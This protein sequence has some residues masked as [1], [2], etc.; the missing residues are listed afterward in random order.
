MVEET[1]LQ[2]GPV[3]LVVYDREK[4][5]VLAVEKGEYSSEGPRRNPI[6]IIDGQGQPVSVGRDWRGWFRDASGQRICRIMRRRG[7]GLRGPLYTIQDPSKAEVGNFAWGRPPDGDH[8]LGLTN[9]LAITAEITAELRLVALGWAI[10]ITEVYAGMSPV[11]AQADR[12]GWRGLAGL[13]G[14]SGAGPLSFAQDSISGL[15][16]EPAMAAIVSAASRRRIR[17]PVTDR[18]LIRFRRAES[19]RWVGVRVG[20]QRSPLMGGV[21]LV[22]EGA[23]A[24][25]GVSGVVGR[26]GVMAV[27]VL[28]SGLLAATAR[29]HGSDFTSDANRICVRMIE[30]S[31]TPPNT[32]HPTAQQW[33]RFLVPPR[34][35]FVA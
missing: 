30:H 6:A 9:V 19:R 11:G 21:A 1:G 2:D 29:A 15:P 3:W 33:V 22:D 8:E 24:R 17:Q 26:W 16:R 4:T 35:D 34:A 14:R 20:H 13:H 28:A 31:P 10:T 5:R 25:V 7:G 27:L 18:D 23:M 12:Q 32:E